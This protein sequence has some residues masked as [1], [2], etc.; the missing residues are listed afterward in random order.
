M[1]MSERGIAKSYRHL[2]GFVS[3]TLSF[4]HAQ[5]E[6]FWIKFHLVTQQSITNLPHGEAAELV[7]R[8]RESHQADLRNAIDHADYSLMDVGVLELN[9]H[10]ENYFAEI[11]QLAFN[12]ANVV[13][14]TSFSPDKML[15]SRL[16]SYGDAQR[17][18]LGMNHHRILVNAPHCALRSS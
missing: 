5:N 14:G 7:G 8:D 12:P 3:H 13:P 9:R 1:L 11:E 16:L 15:P 18:P 10:A 17:Y 2:L 6:R 4:L